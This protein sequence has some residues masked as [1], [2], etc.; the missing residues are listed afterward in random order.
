MDNMSRRIALFFIVLAIGVSLF[1]GTRRWQ[2]ESD[3]SDI[4]VVVSHNDMIELG[5]RAGIPLSVVMA[6]IQAHS[7]A[8]SIAI[9]EESLERLISEG[10]AVML[11]GTEISQSFRFYGGASPVLRQLVRLQ[12]IDSDRYYIFLEDKI[13]FER[14]LSIFEAEM[15]L[16]N[17]TS[18]SELLVISVIGNKTDLLTLGIGFSGKNR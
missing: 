5:Q 9:E 17:V 8:S 13:D 12:P 6:T 10:K 1:V 18:F 11:C 14:I 16:E 7:I 3:N 4:E 15:G 2:F